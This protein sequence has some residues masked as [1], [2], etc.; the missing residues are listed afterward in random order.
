MKEHTTNA[1]PSELSGDETILYQT[2]VDGRI[3]THVP[4]KARE[5]NWTNELYFGRIARYKEI[6][7]LDYTM[8][9]IDN[10]IISL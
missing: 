5:L 7:P 6:D 9:L 4:H 8:H 1:M 3:V 2:R 10:N